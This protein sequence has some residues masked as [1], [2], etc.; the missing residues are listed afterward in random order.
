MNKTEHGWDGRR[1]G[2]GLY[3]SGDATRMMVEET[4]RRA[5][6][7]CYCGSLASGWCDCCSGIVKEDD[8]RWIGQLDYQ[9]A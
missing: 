4:N 1:P 3:Y 5:G 2:Q 8:P 9:S 6:W 7:P